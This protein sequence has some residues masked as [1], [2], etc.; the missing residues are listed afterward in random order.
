LRKP[1]TYGLFFEENRFENKK[2]L[3]H[4]EELSK[5]ACLVVPVGIGEHAILPAGR[6]FSIF[7]AGIPFPLLFMKTRSRGVYCLFPYRFEDIPLALLFPF[8]VKDSVKSIQA[9]LASSVSVKSFP[10]LMSAVSIVAEFVLETMARSI[11]TDASY[12]TY[13]ST[14][15]PI[16]VVEHK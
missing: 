4:L 8:W 12:F 15:P 16:A 11:G 2:T 5:T 3:G 7:V 10:D 13:L 9:F 6:T 14:L 1:I